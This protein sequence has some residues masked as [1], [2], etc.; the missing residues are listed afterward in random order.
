M[1][2][3]ASTALALA[4]ALLLGPACSTT[5]SSSGGAPAPAARSKRMPTPGHLSEE[6]RALLSEKMRDHGDDMTVLLWSILFL[7]LDGSGEYARA[8]ADRPKIEST[9]D[10][11]MPAAIFHWQDELTR[12]ADALA[13]MSVEDKKDPSKFAAAFGKIAE[14]CVSCHNAYL[15]PGRDE[16]SGAPTA[17]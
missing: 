4:T 12:R 10:V 15:Y 3:S 17:P 1:I 8:I 14:T 7:D 2:R 5:G 16:P 13:T 6:A 9:P 11:K